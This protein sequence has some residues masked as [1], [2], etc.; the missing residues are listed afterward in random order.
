MKN[1]SVFININKL[2]S[3]CINK[4]KYELIKVQKLLT[5]DHDSL[6]TFNTVIQAR[7]SKNTDLFSTV[8]SEITY[9]PNDIFNI[10]STDV[11]LDCGAAYGD[12]LPMFSKSKL[13]YAIEPDPNNF[14]LLTDYVSQMKLANV[15]TINVGLW[16]ECTALP[17][18]DKCGNFLT[19]ISGIT[20]DS[21]NTNASY[22]KMDIE[23]AELEALK[24]ASK[25]IKNNKPKL[26]ICVYH[27]PEHIFE[28]PLYLQQIQPEYKFYFRHQCMND[29]FD[30]ILFC[31]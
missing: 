28:I 13:I 10:N 12:T 26:A 8:S 31:K 6:V 24:G 23:G 19:K 27:K 1:N 20:I 22:I 21:L 14:K 29:Y 18:Y 2:T 15:I 25:L 9:T 5:H 16:Y 30:S 4:N 11:V 7:L 17:F 3:E